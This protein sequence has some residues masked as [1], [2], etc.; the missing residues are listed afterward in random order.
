MN[1]H[2]ELIIELT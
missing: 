2:G 1:T